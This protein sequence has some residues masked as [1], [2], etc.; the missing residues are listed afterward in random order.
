MWP[1]LRF[2][3]EIKLIGIETRTDN[4]READP[5]AAG[6]PA[7]WQKF[8]REDLLAKI[9]DRVNGALLGAYTRYAGDHTGSY[10]LI[11]GT[12]VKSLASVPPGMTGLIIPNGHYLVFT[13]EGPMPKALID[14]W[15]EVWKHFSENTRYQRSFATDYEVHAGTD[16]AE[17]HISLK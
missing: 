16:R 12:E 4:A 3:P 5:A 7:L 10:T 1:E 11:V 6:I 2:K 14:T 13:A 8:L 9:P 17:I 15:A